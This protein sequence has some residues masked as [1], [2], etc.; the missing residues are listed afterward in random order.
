MSGW[1]CVALPMALLQDQE[2]FVS[3]FAAIY[4]HSPWVAE[5]AWQARSSDDLATFGAVAAA[6]TH[7]VE[8]A[9]ETAQTYLLKAHPELASKASLAGELTESSTKEQRSAGL[10]ACSP[11]ELQKLRELNAS[12]RARFGF[13]FIVAVTGLTRSDILAAME[14][15]CGA[16]ALSER[17][18]ALNQVHKIAEIR[19][20]AM[21]ETIA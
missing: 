15:R 9:S 4:E 16:M 3:A 18:E 10:E 19:L 8:R 6:M 13:P 14:M 11:K 20:K 12:Y 1:K 2:R 17:R 7:A 21:A 5:N